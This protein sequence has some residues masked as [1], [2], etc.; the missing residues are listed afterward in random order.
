M[1]G[2]IKKIL[3][4]A[5]KSFPNLE[6]TYLGAPTYQVNSKAGGYKEAEAI[7]QKASKQVKKQVEKEKGSFE[8]N[9]NG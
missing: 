3:L 1:G 9:K 6:I 4:D 7:L 5:K 8:F 2:K